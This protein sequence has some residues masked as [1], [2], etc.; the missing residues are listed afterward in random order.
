MPQLFPMN[1]LIISF[2]LFLMFYLLISNLFF[3]KNYKISAKKN[4]FNFKLVEFKW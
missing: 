3:L 1:W 2:I 4:S